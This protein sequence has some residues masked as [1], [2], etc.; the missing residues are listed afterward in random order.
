MRL[1]WR[2]TSTRTFLLVPAVIGVEQALAGRHV[3]TRWMP[4]L[5]VG[6]LQ[7]RLAG[8]YRLRR[9]GGP[10]GMSQGSPERLVVTGPY[11]YTRN[12]MYLGH[13]MFL[14]GLTLVSRS[15]AALAV[16]VAAVPWF[17]TRTRHD[18]ERLT[19]QFGAE[20]ARY[21]ASVPRWI[22]RPAAF[23]RGTLSKP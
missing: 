9:A 17:D 21:A 16:T 4:L 8:E 6:F 22:P 10:P 3:H 20:Y 1:S 13:V 2:S 15:P 12:P 14:A 18:E 5:L 19:A 23:L 7:Y 11:A